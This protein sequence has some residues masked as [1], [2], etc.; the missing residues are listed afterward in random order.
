MFKCQLH[1]N[2]IDNFRFSDV[3]TIGQAWKNNFCIAGC[4][5]YN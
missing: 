5:G 2:K 1:F 3:V 4:I